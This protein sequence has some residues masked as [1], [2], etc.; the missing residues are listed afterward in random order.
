MKTSGFLA[1]ASSVRIVLVPVIMALV[2]MD[3]RDVGTLSIVAG[4]LFAVAAITD[5]FDGYLARRWNVTTTLGSF[6][7]TTA[8]KLLVTGVLVALVAVERV[9][10]WI[11]TIIIGRELVIMG[12]RGVVAADGLVMAPSI[13]GKIKTNVQFFAILLAIVRPD[14]VVAG[15]YADEWLMVAAAI[16]TVGLR[17]RLPRQLLVRAAGLRGRGGTG[18]GGDAGGA[19]DDPRPEREPALGAA[20][21]AQPPLTRAF[22]TGGS[23]L[24]G[25]ALIGAL[26]ARGDEVVALVRSDAAA[27]A[28]REAGATPVAGDLLDEAGVAAAMA[29]CDVGFHVAGVNTLCPSDPS[30]LERINVAGAAAV[31]R[32]AADAGLPRLVHTSSSSTIGEPKGTIGREDTPHR[33]WYLS[34]YDRTK[35]AG[36]RAVL[37]IGAERGLDVVCVNPASVQGPG[38]ATGTAKMLLA[39]LDGRL[40][41]FVDTRISVVDIDDCTRGHLLAA[42]RGAA[43]RA[44]HPVRRDAD[45]RGG[46]RAAPGPERPRRAPP[47][48]PRGHRAA[49]R[50]RRGAR[51]PGAPSR[52]A[53]VPRDGPHAAARPR[54]RRVARDP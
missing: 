4:V 16:I 45:L 30:E 8:D 6:L 15:V 37:E 27:G 39:Q 47:V 48:H 43:G 23:G 25:R 32:A 18:G 52:P 20:D 42:E 36:E 29:G 28:V 21:A 5:F 3:D 11:A 1:A 31:A 17:G 19:G 46:A 34:D 53:R 35:H 40:K 9:S 13:W 44:L 51:L 49:A 26:R 50:G 12:L 41:V 33:G 24:L 54:L 10:P 38:R 2:V 7:D 22:V 14:V